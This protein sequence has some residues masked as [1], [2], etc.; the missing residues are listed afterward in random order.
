MTYRRDKYNKPSRRAKKIREEMN[1]VSIGDLVV[2][3]RP[4]ILVPKG[5]IALVMDVI[6]PGYYRDGNIHTRKAI[7]S[8]LPV[9]S[10]RR[11]QY[12]QTDLEVYKY[13][14][15]ILRKATSR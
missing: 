1:T 4:S 6:T 15:P 11:V 3:Q 2:I 12:V 7:A 9:G 13:A 10:D 8:V 14:C 5:T